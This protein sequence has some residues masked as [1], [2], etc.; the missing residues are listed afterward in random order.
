[1][2]DA[3]HADLSAWVAEHWDATLDDVTAIAPGLGLRR[4]YRLAISG[5]K[6]PAPHVIARVDAEEDPA[7]RAGGVAPEPELEPIRRFLDDHGIPVP[8]RHAALPA[9]RTE[10]LEDAG[11]RSLEA[12]ATDPTT[13]DG[14]RQALYHDACEI[15][16]RLQALSGPAQGVEAFDRR[17]DR[18]LFESKAD[19]VI[20][21]ALPYWLPRA[22]T[23]V[24]ER[25]VR[26]FYAHVADVCDGAPQRLSH[27]D[28]KAANVHL[29]ADDRLVLIDLQGAFL[30]PPEYD[31]VCLL[32][33]SHVELPR[34]EVDAHLDA[35]RARLPDAP[36]AARF[37][38]RFALLTLT[39]V[40]KDAAHYIH[41]YT[42]NDDDRYLRFLPTAR[43]TLIDAAGRCD[44]DD[45]AIAPFIA[46]LA[47][48]REP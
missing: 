31:L 44:P 30:A 15:I 45:E 32:R 41:A 33:D 28:F 9:L 5:D 21:W 8:K 43:R 26:T 47:E 37:A 10:L 25:S 13:N 17:L 14:T 12:V 34:A 35:V 20:R 38:E 27:R 4:F 24:D 2:D 42:G 23:A 3:L 11:D 22:V 29:V 19:R 40:A 7:K 36:D 6:A 48:L 46:L 16:A 39:R 18:A 1:M